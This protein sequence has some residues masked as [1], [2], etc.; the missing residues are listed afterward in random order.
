ME[1][2]EFYKQVVNRILPNQKTATNRHLT[3]IVL[4]NT[5][6]PVE[7]M[8]NDKSIHQLFANDSVMANAY[9]F[10]RDNQNLYVNKHYMDKERVQKE[11]SDSNII[12]NI[13]NNQFSDNDMLALLHQAIYEQKTKVIKKI[14]DKGF[15]PDL[16]TLYFISKLTESEENLPTLQ[17]IESK[18]IHLMEILS[19]KLLLVATLN[20]NS[21][22][23]DFLIQ[24]IATDHYYIKESLYKYV[25]EQYDGKM[26]T[27]D[28]KDN[29][30]TTAH[31]MLP[32]L[33]S[34]LPKLS[35][36]SFNNISA[37]FKSLEMK[38]FLDKYYL[39]HKLNNNLE[40]S[41]KENIKKNKL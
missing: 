38:E 8:F 22:A 34:L 39:S 12:K 10:I 13:N 19:G 30:E 26:M 16:N 41:N 9:C 36:D 20:N 4:Q 37:K 32:I 5:S 33:N 6:I 11:L 2:K 23:V 25:V 3:S 17:Y 31:N 1:D 35:S 7:E 15:K 24:N 29:F 21:S 28:R 40:N 14:M 27:K 18:N